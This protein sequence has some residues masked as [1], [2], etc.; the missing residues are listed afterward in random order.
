VAEKLGPIS[1]HIVDLRIIVVAMIEALLEIEIVVRRSGLV[2]GRSHGCQNQRRWINGGE[3]QCVHNAVT[4]DRSPVRSVRGASPGIV[5]M[6]GIAMAISIQTAEIKEPL[7]LRGGVEQATGGDCL[8]VATAGGLDL[9]G[10][11]IRSE[12]EQLV[13]DDRT[14]DR[15]A[16]LIEDING[17]L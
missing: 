8:R 7:R 6:Y 4:R 2:R 1:G 11:F 17:L 13:L 12:E 3:A 16:K 5:D 9:P 14:T 15:S 10:P